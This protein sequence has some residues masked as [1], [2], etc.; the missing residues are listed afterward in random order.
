MTDLV[1]SRI[2]GGYFGARQGITMASGVLSG[3]LISWI[4]DAFTV[5]GSLAGYTIVFIMAGIFGALDIACYFF[6]EFP[7]MKEAGLDRK[8]VRMT[9]MLRDVLSDRRC[10]RIILLLTAWTFSTSL[11]GPFYHVHMLG[12]MHMTYSQINVLSAV[13]TNVATLLF[14]TRWGKTIDRYGN[15]AVLQVSAFLVALIPLLWLFTGPGRIWVVPLVEFCSGIIWAPVG[16]AVQNTYLYQ[17]P[18]KNRSMYF[19]VYFCFT[20][21]VGITLSYAVGGWLVDHLFLPLS[22]SL[23]LTFLGIP[24]NQY[25]YIFVFSCLVRVLVVLTA[26]RLLPERENDVTP[27]FMLRDALHRIIRKSSAA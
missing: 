6:V 3:F 20:Q 17:A 12:P 22:Q 13:M 27:S 23:A 4:L 16:L 8:R 26:L 15:K 7:S 24:M 9:V 1:P 2:S 21:M 5:D 25:P 14:S 10:G 18:E 11:S 19:A